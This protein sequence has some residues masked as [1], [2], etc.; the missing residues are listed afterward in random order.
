MIS[1]KIA[2]VSFYNEVVKEIGENVK[3]EVN[4]VNRKP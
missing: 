3:S 2:K 4:I 1:I